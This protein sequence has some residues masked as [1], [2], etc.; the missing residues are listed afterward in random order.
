M[1]QFAYVFL[2]SF[3]FDTSGFILYGENMEEKTAV[4]FRNN[5]KFGADADIYIAK[6]IKLFCL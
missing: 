5:M 4:L 2:L 3:V 6:K 1:K